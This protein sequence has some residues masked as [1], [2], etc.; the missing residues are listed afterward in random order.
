MSAVVDPGESSGTPE[1]WTP[2]LIFS[3]VSIVLLLEMLTVGYIMVSITLPA[4]SAHFRTTQGAWVLTVNMLVGA[5]LGPLLGKLAD[6]YGKRR[7]LLACI[8]VAV[9][10]SAI[11]AA[12]PSFGLMVLGRGLAGALTPCVFLAYSL[13]RDVFPAKTVALAVSLV[14]TGLGLFAIP[15]PFLTGWLLDD[16]GFRGVYWCLTIGTAL[17][18]LMIMVST[19]ES[20]VRLRSRMDFAGALLLGLGIA[21]VLVA[22][23]FGPEWGWTNAATLTYLIGGVALFIAWLIS[24]AIVRE[25]LLNLDILRERSIIFVTIG[26]SAAYGLSAL[27]TV[28]LPMIA[29]TPAST[30]LGYGFGISAKG[31]AIFQLPLGGMVVAGGA[32]AG[33]LVGRNMRPRT[34]MITGLVLMA[35]GY[36]CLST[37]YDHEPAVLVAAALLGTGMGFSYASV[38]NLLIEV[39]PPELLT[40]TSSITNTFQ[41][42][43]SGALPVVVFAVLNNS[44]LAPI[45][46]DQLHGAILYTGKGFQVGFQIGAVVAAVGALAAV[47]LPRTLRRVRS[48]QQ[49]VCAQS[50][51]W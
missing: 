47:L 48:E 17:F 45:P 21:G 5:V 8:G 41:S 12:A 16:F 44:Y 34:L 42:V 25:P 7:I 20:Q 51:T 33:V 13:V 4:V 9:V 38:P 43:A 28:L 24:A 19:E 27:V 1:T 50:A 32:I 14:T 15:A 18:G 30:G 11:A 39:V 26:A 31:Y 36:V 3:L 23:S 49:P 29:M 46:A 40:S 10:G 35:A 6:M 2:R 37:L 22:V